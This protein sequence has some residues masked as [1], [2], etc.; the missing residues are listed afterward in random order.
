MISTRSCI[1]RDVFQPHLH[2]CFTPYRVFP[3]LLYHQPNEMLGC[4]LEKQDP[5]KQTAIA[6]CVIQL[7]PPL[8]VLLHSPVLWCASSQLREAL[9]QPYPAGRAPLWGQLMP[10]KQKWFFFFSCQPRL[11][12]WRRCSCSSVWLSCTSKVLPSYHRQLGCKF[13]SMLPA[14]T[15]TLMKF[16][17]T[18]LVKS[19]WYSALPPSFCTSWALL[20]T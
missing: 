5:L 2:P 8:P 9:P 12:H 20:K 14:S 6:G 17:S 3:L 10:A 1:P 11:C 7:L 19:F 4:E 18:D 15:A 13:F 16:S